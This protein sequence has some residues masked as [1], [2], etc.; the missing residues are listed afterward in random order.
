MFD[1]LASTLATKNNC[2]NNCCERRPCDRIATERAADEGNIFT[3]TRPGG[4]PENPTQRWND[5]VV[6]RDFR[7]V[8]PER[9]RP[10]SD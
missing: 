5:P 10:E 2:I 9:S 7:P 6:R 4:L 1:S 3:V 8:I